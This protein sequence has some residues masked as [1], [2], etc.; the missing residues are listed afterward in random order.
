MFRQIFYSHALWFTHKFL[1]LPCQWL[2]PRYVK[3]VTVFFLSGL[4]H[5]Y[6]DVTTGMKIRES[7]SLRV[8]VAQSFGIMLEDVVQE[9]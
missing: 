5:Q 4:L 6:I 3:L 1:R 8:F 2:V 9:I 7:G